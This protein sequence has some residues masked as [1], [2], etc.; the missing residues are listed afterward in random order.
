MFVPEN[1]SKARVPGSGKGSAFSEGV[2]GP[3]HAP[4]GDKDFEFVME[5]GER[6]Q[7][8]QEEWAD[9]ALLGEKAQKALAG[10]TK[11]SQKGGGSSG[12]A[13]MLA[14]AGAPGQKSSLFDLSR[15]SNRAAK[16][17]NMSATPSSEVE[18]AAEMVVASEPASEE[19]AH[20][21]TVTLGPPE[22][23]HPP[24]RSAVKI[25]LEEPYQQGTEGGAAQAGVHTAPKGAIQQKKEGAIPNA[26][27]SSSMGNSTVDTS[28]AT[29]MASATQA[30]QQELEDVIAKNKT[31][32]PPKKTKYP[33]S[34][35]S[36][37]LSEHH[38][39]A[40]TVNPKAGLQA[41][42]Q[43]SLVIKSTKPAGALTPPPG[44]AAGKASE[45]PKGGGSSST[46]YILPKDLDGFIAA[47]DE[48]EALPSSMMSGREKENEKLSFGIATPQQPPVAGMT[49]GKVWNQSQTQAQAQMQSQGPSASAIFWGQGEHGSEA[50][51]VQNSQPPPAKAS[52][53]ELMGK[54]QKSG[55]NQ[56]D[57][58][59]NERNSTPNKVVATAPSSSSG[60]VKVTQSAKLPYGE[61]VETSST[62][63][64]PYSVDV[65][66]HI[67]A[68]AEGKPVTPLPLAVA[69]D[70]A[71][72]A[73]GAAAAVPPPKAGV[74]AVR[75][76]PIELS[77]EAGSASSATTISAAATTPKSVAPASPRKG[78][79]GGNLVGEEIAPDVNL[80]MAE[81]VAP[82]YI[83]V[84]KASEVPSVSRVPQLQA[85]VDRVVKSIQQ[86]EVAGKTD[87]VIELKDQGVFS[88][89]RITISE[90][91][92]SKKQLNITID[93]LTQQSKLLIDLPENRTAL[94]HA[95]SERGYTIQMMVTTTALVD[96]T[97]ILSEANKQGQEESRGGSSRQQEQ[98][99]REQQRDKPAKPYL[100]GG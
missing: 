40:M 66:P 70:Q 35:P 99:Q 25:S 39:S 23:E 49:P 43:S 90:F 51:K 68:A 8:S 52:T 85:I 75:H 21:P 72:P 62:V 79:G 97:P 37:P 13:G 93:N 86:L 44:N 55:A 82:R 22:A 88:G 7:H 11:G 96:T 64:T 69:S 87:T 5:T 15:S 41:Q 46:A 65:T 80:L 26:S 67:V 24:G 38:P 92:S 19:Q 29:A 34:T 31:T 14:A 4:E 33:S 57:S 50:G 56:Q 6:E 59:S 28:T 94:L 10:P 45:V 54:S 58:G 84:D 30:G 9:V 89:S 91:N 77:K 12:G 32:P 2:T 48:A 61:V 73:M 42:P 16:A 81:Q 3:S 71:V 63:E 83:T 60:A 47:N 20:S 95:L 53:A 1:I 27:N 18:A 74:R 98:Q 78:I 100:S 76:S 36:A 17:A